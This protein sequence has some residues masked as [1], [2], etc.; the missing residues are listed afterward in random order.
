MCLGAIPWSG[1]RRLVCGARD[2]DARRLG[3]DEGAKPAGWIRSFQDRGIDV[4][5]DVM[6]PEAREILK[7]YIDR[8]GPVY[9]GRQ[10]QGVPDE[11]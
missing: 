2:E 7:T 8:G 6:R 4:V 1:L 10:G 3:F 11:E 9:N 5:R